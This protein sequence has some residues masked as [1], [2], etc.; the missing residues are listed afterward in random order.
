MKTV[1]DLF[2]LASEC[3]EKELRRLSTACSYSNFPFSEDSKILQSIFFLDLFSELKERSS[4]QTVLLVL[5]PILNVAPPVWTVDLPKLEKE[6]AFTELLKLQ[7]I[8]KPVELMSGSCE[9]EKLRFFLNCLRY[10]SEFR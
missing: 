7:A 2:I 3:G 6:S 1:A 8:Q 4:W 5:K 10:I 9:R